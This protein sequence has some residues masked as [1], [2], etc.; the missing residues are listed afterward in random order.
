MDGTFVFGLV[1]GIALTLAVQ[2]FTNRKI[3]KALADAA[4]RTPPAQA[5]H[6]LNQRRE[7]QD[8]S[9]RLAVLEQI[10]TDEPHRLATEI[11]R[12]R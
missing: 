4:A 3:R 1:M 6:T 12:L 2:Y 11:D 9:R 5:D 8:L 10:V 7:T